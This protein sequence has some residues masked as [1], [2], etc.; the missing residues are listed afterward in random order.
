MGSTQGL[1]CLE[2]ICPSQRPVDPPSSNLL[3]YAIQSL[4]KLA[5]EEGMELLRVPFCHPLPRSPTARVTV[6]SGFEHKAMSVPGVLVVDPGETVIRG[7]E[8]DELI[9]PDL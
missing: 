6:L 5:A 1:M 4:I 8:L 3:L 9:R 2:I 7:H